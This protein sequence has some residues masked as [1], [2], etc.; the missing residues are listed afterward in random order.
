MNLYFP[1]SEFFSSPH[2]GH[3]QSGAVKLRVEKDGKTVEKQFAE[4]ISA[5]IG[6]SLTYQLPAGVYQRFT[7]LAGL[8]PKRDI[9][10]ERAAQS[11]VAFTING[12][13]KKLASATLSGDQPA[14]LFACDITGVARL[15]L[16]IGSPVGDAK[17]NNVYWAEPTLVK[18][19]P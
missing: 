17:S 4:G 19:Q 14:H 18:K 11:R 15:Q 12:D 7:V 3:A 10:A 5:G 8:Y 1:Q 16:V 2:W 9:D 13:G 6:K